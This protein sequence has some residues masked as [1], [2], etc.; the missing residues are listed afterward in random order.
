[1]KNSLIRI[2]FHLVLVLLTL[3]TAPTPRLGAAVPP[4]VGYQGRV[5]VGSL[6][7]TGSGQFRF[8]L[9]D[10]TD[11]SSL[12]SNDGT[13]IAGS[14][15]V[16]AVPLPVTNGLFSVLLGD[17]TQ[18]NMGSLPA[19]LFATH[20]NV[21]LR[22]WFNDGVNSSIQLTPDTRL[23]SAP[24]A[25][26]ADIPD[27]S[28][29]SAKLAPGAVTL[30]RLAV[31]GAPASGQLLSYDGTG[32]TWVNPP[33]GGGSTLSWLLGGNAG[34]SSGNF[35]GTV[36]DQDVRFQ[37]NNRFAFGIRASDQNLT[38]PRVPS[39]TLNLLGGDNG[40]GIY[41]TSVGFGGT[42][43]GRT[44]G[45]VDIG[46]PVLYG[47]FGGGLGVTYRTGGTPPFFFDSTLVEKP[48]LVWESAS[49][50]GG[51]VHIGGYAANGDPKLITFGDADYVHIGEAGSDDTLELKA[52][53]FNFV[54]G[55]MNKL[56]VGDNF[57][58]TVGAADF[59]LGHS[60]RRGTPGRALVDFGDALV[61]NFAGDW[62]R[63]IIGGSSVEVRVLTITGGADLAEPFPLK[64]P[65]LDKGSVVVIDEEH[66]GR[67]KLATTAYDTRV[68]GIISGANGISPGIALHQ[69]GRLEGT[70]NVALS[71]RVYVRADAG[72][73]A[74]KPGDLLTTSDTP[75][76]AMKVTNHVRSQGAVLG[77]AMSSLQD[78]TGLVLVLVSLQ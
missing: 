56:D 49:G 58:A 6:P 23:T 63:T 68:A 40:L 78:G 44:F 37:A 61:L 16:N 62:A 10:Q 35:L 76:H 19:D 32:M 54:G 67:L 27:G 59:K 17:V 11:G 34:T 36:D 46:G 66:P 31:S 41:G 74:I 48:I 7:F 70:D 12:W 69:E 5:A 55:A 1:M 4:L 18:L 57:V 28:L 45:G 20:G 30:S 9:I 52:A 33:A 39:S 72:Y 38:F 73:G 22:V 77:K 47:E 25:L 65:A 14:Q 29:T 75:G 53:R 15:P 60:S 42:T 51:I 26:A 21:R 8:A 2:R 50:A 43:L 3:G 13:S 71:G 64:E 24:Y